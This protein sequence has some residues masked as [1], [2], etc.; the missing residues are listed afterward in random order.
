MRVRTETQKFARVKFELKGGTS[1]Q[2]LEELAQGFNGRLK[3]LL[4]RGERVE[5]VSEEIS[6][7]RR[8]PLVYIY[9]VNETTM[10]INFRD[11]T[12]PVVVWGDLEKIQ[13]NLPVYTNLVGGNLNPFGES[14]LSVY[15][16]SFETST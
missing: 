9:H 1:K 10:K 5:K 13:Q 14:I 2:R 7:W 11:V 6:Y 16:S 3:D 12:I 15:T 4:R 8:K